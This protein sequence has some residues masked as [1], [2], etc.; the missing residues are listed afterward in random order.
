MALVA[1]PIYNTPENKRNRLVGACLRSL[2]RTVDWW[3]RGHRLFLIDDASTDPDLAAILKH[4]SPHLP[5]T[6]LRNEANIGTARSVNRAWLH[7]RP[8]EAAVKMDSDIVLHDPN[9]LDK[10]EECVARDEKLGIVCLKRRDL[11]ENPWREDRY[12]SELVMLPHQPGQRWLAVEKVGHCLGSC[13]LYSPRLLEKIGFLVQWGKY[14]LDDS[15]AAVRCAAVGMYSA[16]LCN[17]DIEHPD[18]GDT[19]YQ[20]W[21]EEYVL[22]RHLLHRRFG[23]EWLNG[24]RGVHYGPD[25]DLD[26]DP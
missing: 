1:I 15:A 21:K 13:Q 6:L 24:S 16:F 26:L 2:L 12:R 19:P 18:P 3:H 7:R 23:V 14:G 5:F 4:Y 25:H 9:W 22:H 8:E 11:A 20:A 17:F 10:L